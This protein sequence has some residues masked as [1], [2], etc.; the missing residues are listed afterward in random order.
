MTI[1]FRS[2]EEAIDLAGSETP[3]EKRDDALLELGS[4]GLK[5]DGGFV[6]EEFLPELAGD[7]A[8]RVYREMRDND[9]VIGAILFAIDM[10][11]RRVQWYVDPASQDRED[12]ERAE[13]VESNMQDMSMTWE[14]TI[15][16][17]MSM[18]IFGWSYHEIVYKKR[19][20]RNED[21]RLNSLYDDGY[22]GWRKIPI[23]AQETLS[24]WV[25]D[26]TGGIQGMVQVA[27][28][29]YTPR[30]IPIEKALLFRTEVRKGNPEGRSI[31]RN[32]YRPWY[33]KKH[34]EEIEGIGIERDLAGLPVAWVPAEILQEK[35]SGRERATLENIRK[36][37]TNV[38]RDEQEG[39]IFPLV[40]DEDGNRMYDLELMSTGG[41][42]QFDT[43]DIIARYDQRIAM[44]AMADFILLGHE[45]VG[46]F[47]LGAS[48]ADL[49]SMALEAWLDEIAAVFN[50]YAIPRLFRINN[51]DVE[52]LP[53]LRPEKIHVPDLNALSNYVSRLAGAGMPLFPDNELE[54]H[55]RE[56]ASLPKSGDAQHEQ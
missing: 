8:R 51:F 29:N 40:Y 18:L 21:S 11:I 28:P 31:L 37:I 52:E 32:A 56:V 26:A 16:E 1:V 13:F 45:N 4:T 24:R 34:I 9:S 7:K 46:S 5:R 2:S 53:K 47:A 44:T 3:D 17:I 36:I 48:K 19:M 27:P 39:V 41:R 42:R 15:S 12:L 6:H 50:R 20:G 43:D 55:L 23:R 14:D 54:N 25:F 38:R 35:A 49:F 10:L 33:F 30:F 22:F